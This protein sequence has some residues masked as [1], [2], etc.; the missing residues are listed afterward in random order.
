[1][2]ETKRSQHTESFIN[3]GDNK[4]VISFGR[5][6]IYIPPECRC[7][8]A[9][10]KQSLKDEKKRIKE[11]KITEKKKVAKKKKVKKRVSLMYRKKEYKISKLKSGKIKVLVDGEIQS[12][13]TKTLSPIYKH[14]LK[15]DVGV[16]GTRQIATSILKSLS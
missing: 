9:E 15:K 8:P 12:N 13:V 10:Y 7:T 11:Q 1:M 16:L 3:Y 2:I 6:S 4:D 14:I 5:G